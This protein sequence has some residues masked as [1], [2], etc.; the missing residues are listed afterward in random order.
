MAHSAH[1]QNS[2]LPQNKALLLAAAAH[3]LDGLAWR[4]APCEIADVG[5]EDLRETDLLCCCT[6]TILSRVETA[7][8]ARALGKP[9]LDGAVLGQGIAEGRVTVYPAA[10]AAACTLCGLAEDRR[11][12]VLGYA[13]S[14]SLGCQAP[15]EAPVMRAAL[16]TLDAV[17][18]AML[19]RIV[20][21]Q[22]AGEV[23]CTTKLVETPG[24][25]WRADSVQLTRS[26]G[27]PWHDDLQGTFESLAWSE[28]VATALNAGGRELVLNWPV[29]TEAACDGCGLRSSPMQRVARVRRAPCPVCGQ[30]RQQPLRVIHRIRHGDPSSAFSPRQL[31]MP[32][33]HLYWLR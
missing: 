23:S 11:A 6:D 5:W 25:T 29:C 16:A 15:E 21:W 10:R 31:G 8:I 4:S 3:D 12:A 33:R 19:A 26:A 13:A 24:R 1:V 27:C 32:E 30:R 14:A 18:D 2:A 28:P 22:S 20:E 7:W 17:A 9:M